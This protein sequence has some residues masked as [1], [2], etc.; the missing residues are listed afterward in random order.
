[1]HPSP[2]ANRQS[3]IANRQSPIANRQSKIANRQSKI[4]NRQSPMSTLD[5]FRKGTTGIILLHILTE[6]PMYG[7]EIIQELEQRSQGY[8]AFKEGLLYPALHEMEADG[9]VTSFWHETPQGRR[10]RYY[11][12]TDR[13]R[14]A[15]APAVQEWTTF[16]GNLMALLRPAPS[17]GS[18]P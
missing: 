4:E 1:M 18:Q 7:Y 6:R 15:L 8:F 12:I 13:G 2:I 10:R 3:P 14:A 11:Q 9:L 5:Q 17:G 16:A